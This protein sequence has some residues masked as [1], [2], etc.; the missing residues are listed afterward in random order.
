[1]QYRPR[2]LWS[3]SR[4]EE[5][6]KTTLLQQNVFK[7]YTQ[8]Y[9]PEEYYQDAYLFQA[10]SNLLF[11]INQELAVKMGVNFTLFYMTL[12]TL[13]TKKHKRFIKETMLRNCKCVLF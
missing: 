11:P 12:R 7:A 1:M 2:V 6:K 4:A 8:A 5:V 13:G 10:G 3:E 9:N